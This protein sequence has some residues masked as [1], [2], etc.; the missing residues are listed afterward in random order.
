ME[1][2]LTLFLVFGTHILT[3]AAD[4]CPYN[5]KECSCDVHLLSCS[6]LDILPPLVS[7]N[8]DGSIRI[9]MLVDNN[10]K[11]VPANS[12]PANLSSIFFLNMPITYISPDAFNTSADTLGFLLMS[13][14]TYG[15][16]PEA[17]LNVNNLTDL[18][19]SFAPI[20]AWNTTVLIHLG[21][22]VQSLDISYARLNAWPDV[23]EYFYNVTSVDFSNN[24]IA[25][26]PNDAFANQFDLRNISLRGNRLSNAKML[27]DAL[28]SVASTL[29]NLDIGSNTLPSI[30]SCISGMSRLS[31]LD[32]SFNQ[33]DDIASAFPPQIKTL[34][35]GHNKI[36]KLTDTT[37]LK[38]TSLET[39][40]LNDNPLSEISNLA[41]LPIKNLRELSL[42]SISLFKIPEALYSL[43]NLQKLSLGYDFRCPCSRDPQLVNWYYSLKNVSIS[44]YCYGNV[45]KMELYF[46]NATYKQTC[47]GSNLRYSLYLYLSVVVLVR[48]CVF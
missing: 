5:V 30:P 3:S 4:S 24:V 26:I 27:D 16:I 39:L 22:S 45:A 15:Q 21:K 35:L 37:F 9:L 25:S 46:Q 36:K 7:D 20:R 2:M 43:K 28:R 18:T 29:V 47:S 19:F 13:N 1:L 41:F 38:L 42:E 14:V 34:Y 33:I 44:G 23:F 10:I 40:Y 32:I 11:T 31:R 12:L 6:G 17:L 8:S 48:L